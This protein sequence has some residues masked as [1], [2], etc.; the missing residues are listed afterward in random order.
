MAR[1]SCPRGSRRPPPQAGSGVPATDG[2]CLLGRALGQGD[3]KRRR[4]QCP[5]LLQGWKRRALLFRT[6][7]ARASV[8]P[9]GGRPSLVEVPGMYS[10]YLMN[11]QRLI[12]EKRGD[13]QTIWGAGAQLP[14]TSAGTKA[15]RV[16]CAGSRQDAG[17]TRSRAP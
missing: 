9:S 17:Q 12:P 10:R 16:H 6:S 7:I 8:S 4:T 11:V 3:V 13:M 1:G 5:F 14:F 15:R 2:N